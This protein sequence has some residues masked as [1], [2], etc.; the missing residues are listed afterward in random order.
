ME[1]KNPEHEVV[2]HVAARRALQ[3]GNWLVCWG[4]QEQGGSY[5]GSSRDDHIVVE[6]W[7]LLA[8]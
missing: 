3:Q 8:M 1:P 7:V 4:V 5:A 2:G 6:K